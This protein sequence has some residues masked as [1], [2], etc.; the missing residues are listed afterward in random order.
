MKRNLLLLAALSCFATP[1]DHFPMASLESS[2]ITNSRSVQEKDQWGPEN[3]WSF[4]ELSFFELDPFSVTL[5]AFK[6]DLH[7]NP[8]WFRSLQGVTI[9][10]G[11][12]VVSVGDGYVE[13][14]TDSEIFTGNFY[15][16]QF[17]P[18]INYEC[19][20]NRFRFL[21]ENEQ[22][23]TMV[24]GI[25]TVFSILYENDFQI[26]GARIDTSNYAVLRNGATVSTYT[27]GASYPDSVLNIGRYE[28]DAEGR[29]IGEYSLS[30][31]E[32]TLRYTLFDYSTTGDSLVKEFHGYTKSSETTI[33]SM[34]KSSYYRY[35]YNSG[36]ILTTWYQIM[37]NEAGEEQ[38]E[39]KGTQVIKSDNTIELMYGS[40][41]DS[42]GLWNEKY[43]IM[44]SFN[45]NNSL[46]EYEE[47]TDWG[48]P[49]R[50]KT[51]YTYYPNGWPS[52]IERLSFQEDGTWKQT[53]L[54]SIF[55]SGEPLNT[56]PVSKAEKSDISV[57]KNGSELLMTLPSE[58][59]AEPI[60]L[61]TINGRKIDEVTPIDGIAKIATQALSSG[62]YFYRVRG[63][64]GKFLVK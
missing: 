34:Y 4:R 47:L 2:S 28:H 50:N 48:V 60:S 35:T 14:Y 52:S 24:N 19:Q 3:G 40:Q 13:I 23:V 25:D 62:V 10:S 26:A 17:I 56:I 27:Y 29:V 42:I 46:E 38:F 63:S 16:P 1:L 30:S 20:S 6:D 41:K 7:F 37:H 22:M 54:D 9:T 31:S 58:L 8:Y 21:Y 33:D 64:E 55:Y 32:D 11:G 53:S 59:K 5:Y 39:M 57:M 18:N 51:K 36:G 43:R 44:M 15:T 61:F 45:E 49:S 12:K